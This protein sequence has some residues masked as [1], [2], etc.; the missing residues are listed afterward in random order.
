MW[1]IA[2][3]YIS[4]PRLALV[5]VYFKR[6]VFWNLRG[7]SPASFPTAAGLLQSQ[8]CTKMKIQTRQARTVSVLE[9]AKLIITILACV[10]YAG[11][12]MFTRNSKINFHFKKK[13]GEIYFLFK[14]RGGCDPN[15]I[16]SKRA[17]ERWVLEL[18]RILHIFL[19]TITFRFEASDANGCGSYLG[20][21]FALF[22]LVQSVFALDHRNV[23][24]FQ[25]LSSFF[26]HFKLTKSRHNWLWVQKIFCV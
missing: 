4:G 8:K 25:F 13:S 5:F 10:W 21:F 7:V 22:R 18:G 26:I 19:Y 12:S 14:K 6:F 2:L 9:N 17:T 3:Y 1:D 23:V 20:Y 24:V 11:Y 16:S 15:G